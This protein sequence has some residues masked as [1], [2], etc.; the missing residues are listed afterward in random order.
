MNVKSVEK[1]EKSMVALVIEAN[2][3]EPCTARK[4]ARLAGLLGIS[5]SARSLAGAVK[6][7]CRRLGLPE[8]LRGT[9]DARAVAQDAKADF[10]M[11]GNEKTFTDMELEKI[12][13][14]VVG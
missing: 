9:V 8:T 1:L 4:Y 6:R 10:C 13:R 14:E 3:Q 11:A 5:P 12:I 7:L 2:A